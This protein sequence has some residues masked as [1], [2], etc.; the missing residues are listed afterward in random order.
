MIQ[1]AICLTSFVTGFFHD[2][3][4]APRPLRP[5]RLPAPMSHELTKPPKATLRWIVPTLCNSVTAIA[6]VGFF[7]W[8][9]VHLPTSSDQ[10]KVNARYWFTVRHLLV[11]EF[12]PGTLS[13]ALFPFYLRFRKTGLPARLYEILTIFG[14]TWVMAVLL[15]LNHL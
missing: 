13:V 3:S 6:I 12:L 9:F 15:V 11:F 8:G 1:G 10:V 2:R 7:A 5:R 4:R 14:V